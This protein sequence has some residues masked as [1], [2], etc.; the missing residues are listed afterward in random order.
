[1]W[2]EP[3]LG[4]AAGH[5][6]HIF[7][8]CG[9]AFSSP[10]LQCLCLLSWEMPMVWCRLKELPF[11]ISCV[12][13]SLLQMLSLHLFPP[14]WPDKSLFTFRTIWAVPPLST[15]TVPLLFHCSPLT[16]LSPGLEIP[17][18]DWP[19]LVYL[20]N[21]INIIIKWGYL[22]TWCRSIFWNQIWS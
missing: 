12:S 1:M 13:C 14:H 18:T 11:F 22:R 21:I 20:Q 2:R 7:A 4:C 6:S 3:I 17:W 5:P 16:C 8:S 9:R 19:C 15:L 10:V